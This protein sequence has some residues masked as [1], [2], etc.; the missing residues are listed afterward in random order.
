MCVAVSH[1]ASFLSDYYAIGRV[2]LRS[3]ACDSN[4][5]HLLRIN[6]GLLSSFSEILHQLIGIILI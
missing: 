6:V 4:N 5:C 3:V 1:G 2:L